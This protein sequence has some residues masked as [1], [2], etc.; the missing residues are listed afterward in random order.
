MINIKNKLTTILNSFFIFIIFY[1]SFTNPVSAQ[2]TNP[3]LPKAKQNI[4]HPTIFLNRFLKMAIGIF[5]MVGILYFL[6][7]LAM[8]A[9]HLIATQGDKNKFQTAKDELTHAFVGLTI[10]FSL[11]AILKLIGIVFGINSLSENLKLSLPS[12]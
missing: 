12:L 10:L 9:Y 1:F 6:W 3:L 11:F 4:N 8:G 2:I 5:F 7:H